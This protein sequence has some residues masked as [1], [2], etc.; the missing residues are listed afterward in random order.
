MMSHKSAMRPDE[1]RRVTISWV[2]LALVAFLSLFP[3]F[4]VVMTSLNTGNS[5]ATGLFPDHYTFSH[6]LDVLQHTNF[7][8]WLRNTFIVG[9]ITG[10]IQVAIVTLLAYAFSR[11]T[12]VGRRYGLV[13]LL[14]MQLFPTVMALTAQYYLVNWITENWFPISDNWIGLIAIYAGTSVPYMAWLYKG[15]I[16]TL[17][18]DLEESAYIDGAGRW[19]AFWQVILPLCRPMM[20]VTF[21]TGFLGVANEYILVSV[22]VTDPSRKTFSMGLFDFATGQFE[23]NWTDF[24]AAAVMG[25][26]PFVL[27]FVST[28][29]WLVSG[30]A[31]GAVKG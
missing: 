14:A 24:A 8:I 3:S 13:I 9:M 31:G 28:Q 22:L 25:S 27:L 7:L 19:Q 26:I 12:F 1:R 2:V 18:Y 16:D 11:F 23:T 15:Y 30:L 4:W 17:P 10:V 5:F 21:I 29:R 20:A 6:Y